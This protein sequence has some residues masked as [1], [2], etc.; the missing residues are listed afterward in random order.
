MQ[1]E[2]QEGIPFISF[3]V[4]VHSYLIVHINLMIRH[5]KCGF[6]YKPTCNIRLAQCKNKTKQQQQYTTHRIMKTETKFLHLKIRNTHCSFIERNFHMCN[7]RIRASARTRTRCSCERS[8]WA[9]N[10]QQRMK[11]QTTVKCIIHCN[12]RLIK[13]IWNETTFTHFPFGNVV[14]K[15][16]ERKRMRRRRKSRRRMRRTIRISTRLVI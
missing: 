3:A 15:K 9:R 5:H 12:K 8:K 2:E 7:V 4:S 11:N 14:N 6:I 13:V 16:G 10:A 1:Q